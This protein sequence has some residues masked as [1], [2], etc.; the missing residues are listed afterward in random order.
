MLEVRGHR[1][2][3]ENKYAARRLEGKGREGWQGSAEVMIQPMSRR[4]EKFCTVEATGGHLASKH[5][6]SGKAI[7]HNRQRPGKAKG[8]FRV[9]RLW[10]EI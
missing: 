5:R 10:L 7:Q 6:C 8:T 2:L 9:R 4:Q 3:V 1:W